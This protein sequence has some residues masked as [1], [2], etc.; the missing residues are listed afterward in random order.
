MDAR[1]QITEAPGNCEEKFAVQRF[2][3]RRSDVVVHRDHTAN[4]QD[5]QRRCPRMGQDVPHTNRQ[6]LL[7]S[8][9]EALMLWNVKSVS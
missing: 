5:E 9:V 3:A 6:P 2:C 7:N 4:L 1:V 8:D